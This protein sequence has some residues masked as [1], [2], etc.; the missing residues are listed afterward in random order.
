MRRQAVA[1]IFGLHP[2]FALMAPELTEEK[3]LDISS[4]GTELELTSETLEEVIADIT[5]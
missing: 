1:Y 4:L 5:G 3:L 2:I